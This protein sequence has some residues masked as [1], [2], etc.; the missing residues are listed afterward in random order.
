M[1]TERGHEQW[2]NVIIFYN[3]VI[4]FNRHLCKTVYSDGYCVYLRLT[5]CILTC[6]LLVINFIFHHCTCTDY[7]HL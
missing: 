3:D 7:L 5:P 1:S 6:D 4:F 2:Q